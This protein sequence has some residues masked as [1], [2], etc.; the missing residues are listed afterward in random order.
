MVIADNQ[1]CTYQEFRLTMNIAYGKLL[2]QKLYSIH[3]WIL[4]YTQLSSEL[5]GKL[6]FRDFF[7]RS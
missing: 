6:S 5:G 3:S 7:P 2:D 1:E 4:K